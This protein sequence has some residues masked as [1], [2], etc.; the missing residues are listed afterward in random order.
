MNEISTEYQQITINHHVFYILFSDIYILFGSEWKN[1]MIM[2]V[3]LHLHLIR[4][5]KLKLM[6]HS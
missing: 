1:S 6:I 3:Y 4:F 5:E 2:K